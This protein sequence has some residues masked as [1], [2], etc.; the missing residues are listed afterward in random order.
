M[1]RVGKDLVSC[2]FVGLVDSD[3]VFCEVVVTVKSDF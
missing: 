2:S 1:T 3:G